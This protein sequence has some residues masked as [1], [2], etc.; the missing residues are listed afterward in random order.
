MTQ[1]VCPCCGAGVDVDAPLVDLT[2]NVVSFRG[3]AVS[4]RPKIAEM[5]HVLLAKH[6]SP[7][8]RSSLIAQIWATGE[9]ETSNAGI[10]LLAYQAR[11]ALKG[12]PLDVRGDASRGYRLIVS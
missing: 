6:P 2:Q 7:V 3:R 8:P 5:I 10:R 11:L 12:W 9:P 4:V 1:T